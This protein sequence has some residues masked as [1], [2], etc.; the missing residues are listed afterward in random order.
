MVCSLPSPGDNQNGSVIFHCVTFERVQSI[1]CID[2]QTSTANYVHSR[3]EN[4]SQS[5][6]LAHCS[7]HQ[8]RPSINTE[9]YEKRNAART[10]LVFANEIEGGAPSQHCTA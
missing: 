3:S 9:P 7:V 2:R 6:R 4:M 5:Y 1:H 8:M 10:H